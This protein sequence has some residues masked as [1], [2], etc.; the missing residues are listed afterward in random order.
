[1]QVNLL[2]YIVIKMDDCFIR[3]YQ[4]T[5][6]SIRE[7]WTDTCTHRNN[8]VCV[9]NWLTKCPLTPLHKGSVIGGLKRFEHFRRGSL[10]GSLL[11]L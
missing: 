11:I 3:N 2:L 7:Y 5:D 6:C 8:Y 9:Y 10:S 1:M 4:V